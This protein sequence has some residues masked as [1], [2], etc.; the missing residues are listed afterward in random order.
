MKRRAFLGF[1]GGAAAAGPKLAAGLAD[2]ASFG[3][4]PN[5]LSPIGQA[6][7][8]I[9]GSG[10]W[11]PSR[12]AFLQK[13]LGDRKWRDDDRRL[14]RMHQLESVERFRLD[15][16]RSISPQHKMRMFI[17]GNIDRQERIRQEEYERELADLMSLKIV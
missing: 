8:A 16:L 13:W 15:S 4:V 6:G 1:M 9:A 2:A 14:S 17:E 12:V 3:P 10:D 11:R 7:A 5:R